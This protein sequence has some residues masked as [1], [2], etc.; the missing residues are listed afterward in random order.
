M[1]ELALARNALTSDRADRSREAGIT[2]LEVVLSLMIAAA[3]IISAVMFFVNARG[4]ASANDAIRQ[5]QSISSAVSSLYGTRADFDGLTTENAIAAGIFPDSMVSGTRVINGWGG[6]VTVE[7][8]ST[9][10]TSFDLTFEGVPGDACI[11]LVSSTGS[12]NSIR[13]IK[14]G[15]SSVSLPAS[16]ADAAAA[17][18]EDDNDITWTLQ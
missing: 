1:L 13:S 12:G 8:N 2:L 14:V 17:C 6:D 16:P 7:T 5:V 3:V 11:R 9:D 18:D 4:G 10:S 15:A